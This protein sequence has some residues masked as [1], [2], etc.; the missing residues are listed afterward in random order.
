[1]YG[2]DIDE[3]NDY[4]ETSE[5]E[6]HKANGRCEIKIIKKNCRKTCDQCSYDEC[7]EYSPLPRILNKDGL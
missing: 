6:M 5:C 7:K 3:C 4:D 1:M 2:C